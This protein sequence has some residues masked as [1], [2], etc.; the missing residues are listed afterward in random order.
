MNLTHICKQKEAEVEMI[1]QPVAEI[2]S[3]N[4]HGGL[5]ACL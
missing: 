1:R 2:H 4:T 3:F 5:N